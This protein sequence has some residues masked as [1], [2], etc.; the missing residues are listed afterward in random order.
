MVVLS[1]GSRADASI[2]QFGPSMPCRVAGTDAAMDTQGRIYIPGGSIDGEPIATVLRFDE[3]AAPGNQWSVLPTQ[4]NL[5]TPRVASA[6]ASDALGRIYAIGGIS[7][8]S[9]TT[10]DSVERYDP[11]VGSWTCVAPLPFARRNSR[12]LAASV[13]NL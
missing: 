3:T 4:S 7:E 10:L 6:I 5:K 1:A 9:G 13:Q 8:R 2:W 12:V 11:A